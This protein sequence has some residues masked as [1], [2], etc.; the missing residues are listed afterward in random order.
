MTIERIALTLLAIAAVVLSLNYVSATTRFFAANQAYDLLEPS[1][2]GF[3][4]TGVDD[5]VLVDFGITNPSSTDV[6]ILQVRVTL[7]AG[8]QGVGGGSVQVQESLHAGESMVV[9]IDA[10]ISDRTYVRNLDG[11]EISWLLSGEIQVQL[12]PDIEPVWVDFRVRAE[13][14]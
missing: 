10:V 14:E 7:R 12:D 8:L 3:T 5:P 11:T 2:E 4:F 13:S 1:L 6:S 9:R